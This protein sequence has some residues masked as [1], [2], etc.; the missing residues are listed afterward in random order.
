[1]DGTTPHRVDD[2]GHGANGDGIE[3]SRSAA[4]TTTTNKLN[5]AGW[6]RRRRRSHTADHP[7]T[8][9]P[10]GDSI[11]TGSGDDDR[12]PSSQTPPP[13]GIVAAQHLVGMPLTFE[14][15]VVIVDDAIDDD[16]SIDDTDDRARKRVRGDYKRLDDIATDHN[17]NSLLDSISDAIEDAIQRVNAQPE[18]DTPNPC[19]LTSAHRL[20]RLDGMAQRLTQAA[21]EHRQHRAQQPDGRFPR[22]VHRR[23][24]TS[25]ANDFVRER[26]RIAH[27][28]GKHYNELFHPRGHRFVGRPE[29]STASHGASTATRGFHA[30]MALFW[31]DTLVRFDRTFN[32]DGDL[33]MPTL[34]NPLS[35]RDMI[36]LYNDSALEAAALGDKFN[37]PDESARNRKRPPP[38]ETAPIDFRGGA[39]LPARR[40]RRRRF[41]DPHFNTRAQVVDDGDDDDNIE[42]IDGDH[43]DDNTE[44]RD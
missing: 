30:R 5:G 27:A 42:A 2:D 17:N 44:N 43:S 21:I 8:R 11:T 1:M 22:E 6:M 39:P 9:N 33:P 32:A 7:E 12:S 41:D 15:H 20:A 3:Q 4:A 14:P 36:S 23:A 19:A 26:F 24:R 18:P 34:N 38:R 29:V 16:G 31:L 28:L 25:K 10:P 13:S 37:P 40:G 35:A